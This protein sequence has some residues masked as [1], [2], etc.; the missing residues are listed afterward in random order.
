MSVIHGE[1]MTVSLTRTLGALQFSESYY[2]FLQVRENSG[3]F[4]TEITKEPLSLPSNVEGGL[5]FFNTHFPDLQ[6][7]DLNEF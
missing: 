7:F 6:F 1:I 3:N 4:L 5:G 2:Q